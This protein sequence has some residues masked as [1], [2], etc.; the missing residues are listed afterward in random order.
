MDCMK[1]WR[2]SVKINAPQLDFQADEKFPGM[3][4]V[5]QMVADE[6]FGRHFIAKCD[7]DVGKIVLVEQ[8]YVNSPI[9]EKSANRCETCLKK[10]TN[11]IPCVN[12]ASA[13]FCG[14]KCYNENKFHK[15]I[16]GKYDPTDD[17]HVQFGVRSVL[18]A[19]D[20]FPNTKCLIK[21]V[22]NV[23]NEKNDMEVP[24]SLTDMKSKYRMFLKLNLWMTDDDKKKWL[25][26]GVAVFIDMMM[27][28]PSIQTKLDTEAKE[29]FLMHLC[30]MHYYIICCVECCH[31][32]DCII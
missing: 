11:L 21:F 10:W 5:L 18:L 2:T 31:K 13:L 3:A 23:I 16:C 32:P 20:I 29:R 25:T 9:L 12:C 17:Q 19:M 7:I 1:L 14:D 30:V 24:N 22:E 26:G 28:I 4:N 27:S 6:K 8:T 15:I